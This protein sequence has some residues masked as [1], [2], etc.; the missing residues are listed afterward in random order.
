LTMVGFLSLGLFLITRS[1]LVDS[2]TGRCT[3]PM[4]D[5]STRNSH[6]HLLQ[7]TCLKRCT[8]PCFWC[9]FFMWLYPSLLSSWAFVFTSDGNALKQRTEVQIFHSVCPKFC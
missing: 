1:H 9:W 3:L 4:T 7:N 6:N 8:F 2:H 5:A